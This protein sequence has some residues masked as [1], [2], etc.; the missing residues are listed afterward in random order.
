MD[1]QYFK[2]SIPNILSLLRI[3]LSFALI[4]TIYSKGL[5]VGLVLL[6]GLTDV[7]D[8]YIARKYKWVTKLGA[9]LD[10][11]SDLVFFA[12]VLLI[13]FFRYEQ[14]ITD[15]YSWF[16]I[17]LTFKLTTGVLSRIKYGE[18][19]FIHTIANKLTGFLVFV[20]IMMIPFE[21]VTYFITGVFMMAI[22]AA[23]E[24]LAI[25]ILNKVPDLNQKSIF[26]RRIN[27]AEY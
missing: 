5:F 9:K 3:L 17:T 6:I 12:I 26:K 21:N 4:L 27:D 2:K 13:I 8:G 15:N 23:A 1:T 7:A 24:E 22:L 20:A 25:T 11:L 14:I 10:S 19:V 16:L 18:F